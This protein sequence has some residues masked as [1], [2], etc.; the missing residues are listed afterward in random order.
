MLDKVFGYILYFRSPF[1]V[2]IFREEGMGK[3]C[4]SIGSMSSVCVG[5]KE[6]ID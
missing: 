1:G 2:F 4:Q 3:G 6:I 5:I